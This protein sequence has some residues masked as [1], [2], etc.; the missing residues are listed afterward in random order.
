MWVARPGEP[1]TPSKEHRAMDFQPSERCR[2]FQD[3]LTAFMD[4]RIYAA[5]AVY[6]EQLRAAGDPH[7]QPP[8]MEELKSE[9]RERGLW[10]M[11]HPNPEFGAGLTNTDY[12]P[13]AELLGRSHIASEATNCAAPDTGN[14]EVLTQFGSPEQ[15]DRWLRPLLDGDIRS[16]FAMTEPEVAS[17][18]ATN[19]ALRIERDGDSY[20]LNGRTWWTS[21][22][23]HPNAKIM[24]VMGKT[25]PDAPRH[26]Q[27]SM[28]LVPFDT[29]GV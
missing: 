1:P 27:Q 13:L 8:I 16:S 11:F 19:I 26:Q 20:V 29:A 14:M 23:L 3:R 6:E 22:A 28:V 5:E 17:S 25:S 4:E 15:Q 21:G 10:N 2:E 7:A 9:A 18:D 12:A 24:I